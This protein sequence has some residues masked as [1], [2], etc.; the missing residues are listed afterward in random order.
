MRLIRSGDRSMVCS[1]P[2]IYSTRSARPRRIS[3]NW[4]FCNLISSLIQVPAKSL[5]T[6]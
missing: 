1:L 5:R 4:A 2:R 6:D 3:S